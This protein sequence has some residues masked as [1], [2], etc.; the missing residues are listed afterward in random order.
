MVTTNSG[1]LLDQIVYQ[2][3]KGMSTAESW[4]ISKPDKVN[5]GKAA[6]IKRLSNTIYVSSIT[7]AEIMIKSSLGK[8]DISFDPIEVVKKSGFELLD[9]RGNYAV[10]LKEMPFF[11]RVP[12]DRMLI[13]QSIANKFH[14]LSD[15]KKSKFYDCKLLL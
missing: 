15:D 11:H 6:E 1:Y 12:F 5:P 13:A 2:A 14:I 3:V 10:L 8:L 4:A 7:I 9:C